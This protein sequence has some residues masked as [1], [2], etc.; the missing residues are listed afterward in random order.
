MRRACLLLVAVTT[1]LALL[2]SAPRTL[3]ADDGV[4]PV[5]L[6]AT[7][8]DH[9]VAVTGRF[10]LKLEFA[11]KEDVA[12]P[13]SVA[14][15]LSA[16]GRNLLTL[17]H[18]PPTP[19]RDW[20]KGAKVS[21]AVEVPFPFDANLADR[22]S[23]EVWFGFVDA[24]TG[25]TRPP[26]VASG[27]LN[28]LV[29]IAQI[30]IPK[31][32]GDAEAALA[33]A[34]A[35]VKEGRK[36]AA[37]DALDLGLRRAPDDPTKYR[38]RDAMVKVGALA[39]RPLSPDEEQVVA[40]RIE[41]EK[42]R[43]L[44]E[45]AGRFLD[46]KKFHAALRILEAIGG[47][48]AEQGNQ[49]VLGAV[50]AQKRVEQD[51]QDIREKLVETFTPEEQAEAEAAIKV[52][53]LTQDLMKRA[54]EW[55]KARK[56]AV[57]R[58]AL[59]K[60]YRGD[61]GEA[62][63]A[64]YGRLKAVEKEWCAATPPD[65]QALVDA[66][67]NHPSFARTAW[68]ASREFVFIG[69]KTLVEGIPAQ[70]KMRFDL[71]YVFLTDLFGRRPN[72]GGDRV[73]VYFKELFDF[74]GG[75]GGG[76]TIDIG[77]A[78][79]N[80][81]ETRVDNGLL[82]HELTHCI[83]DTEPIYAGFREG[84]ANFG[85]AYTFEALGQT[86]DLL[87][88]FDSNL[89]AFRRDYL[90]RDLEYWRIPNYGP[91]AGFFL[92]FVDKYAKTKSGHDWSGWRRFFREYRTAPVRDGREPF[93]IRPF[94]RSLV[95]AFGPGAFDDLIAFRF[96][97]VAA[98]RD[99]IGAE[100]EAFESGLAAV[101][102]A[103][104]NLKDAPNSPFPRD[105]ATRYALE[106][107]QGGD[108]DGARGD[109][110]TELGIVFDWH[111]IGPFEEKGADPGSFP[112]PPEYEI[113]FARDYP[114]KGNICRWT[115]AGATGAVKIGA[116]GWVT[117]DYSYQ[118]D[119]SCYAL[120]HATVPADTEAWAWLR[121]DDDFVLFVNGELAGSYDGRWIEATQI[122]W[123]GPV[124]NVPDAMRLP[125]TLRKGRN[126]ILVKVRNRGG[127]SGFVLALSRRD[128]KPIEGLAT[129]LDPPAPLVMRRPPPPEDHWK[130]ATKLE[131]AKSAKLG[132]AVGRFEIAN[133]LLVG[134][135]QDKGV[136]WRKYTVR[137]GFPKDSPSNL[138]WL[139]AK[140][141]EGVDA[142]RVTVQT[143]TGKN[144]A[145]KIALTFQGEGENDGLSGWTLILRPAGEGR[146]QASL[147]RYDLEV[148]TS[149]PAGFA[150]AD[151]LDVAL[152]YEARRV[153]VRLANAA[154]LTDVPI[155]P[156]PGRHRIGLS[157]W[158]PEVKLA[159]IDLEVPKR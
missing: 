151:T 28:G 139:P 148:Y 65:Q 14:I 47:K 72:P 15:V 85:A 115:E 22:D 131:F 23:V 136:A 155:D 103:A 152:T 50:N 29:Q 100:V 45:A 49:A 43:V 126:R 5:G 77:K 109:A 110:R 124:A 94:A 8:D 150:W 21:Y 17:R 81:K 83:D 137:P 61:D 12:H 55:V 1:A 2:A 82:Y 141:T 145:P 99:A 129:D 138:A 130:R 19:T 71:A 46:Q 27:P 44:R 147:E 76:K 36:D 125:V 11:P 80:A 25:T 134:M 97:L 120:T 56:F 87:H 7:V 75:I 117:F 116:T 73:T 86:G 35:L 78:D 88:A 143:V 37:W 63:K 127:P 58:Y 4:V 140:T 57:A 142:F 16:G 24:E 112:F 59:N 122:G 101:T 154:L 54:E 128:G 102:V 3:R 51:A 13:F 30:A 108:E 91:S 41:D 114:G 106:K 121:A 48:L 123:R 62:G 40:K 9:E 92:W 69:P 64:A 52:V 119:T 89:D 39:P 133:K 144:Q 60:L 157:T 96:P 84:L 74:G 68:V 18:A 132:V 156:I 93:L 113:D 135:S 149:A 159:S 95:A 10:T 79:P 66:A 70:S 33:A 32:S 26:E 38:F 105:A 104:E 146:A 158:G 31:P 153:T 53:G 118:D 67:V 90:A 107:A 34:D 42:Q 98:D 111:C 6:V 20:K